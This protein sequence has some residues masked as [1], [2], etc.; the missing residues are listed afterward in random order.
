MG[1]QHVPEIAADDDA[2]RGAALLVG[3]TGQ[4]RMAPIQIRADLLQR[5]PGD[6]PVPGRIAGRRRGIERQEPARFV[7]ERPRHVRQRIGRNRKRGRGVPV[8]GETE[9]EGVSRE[10]HELVEA[11]ILSPVAQEDRQTA[12]SG[13][14]PIADR[15]IRNAVH[16]RSMEFSMDVVLVFRHGR[17]LPSVEPR[18][19]E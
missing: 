5:S 14:P 12:E 2:P 8:G 9:V 11:S 3:A 13:V 17:G 10:R 7:S 6:F 19:S 4:D 15:F 1:Q 16:P 18:E